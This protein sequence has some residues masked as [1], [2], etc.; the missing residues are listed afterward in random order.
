MKRTRKMYWYE[1]FAY[2][3]TGY[4]AMWMI[5]GLTHYIYYIR[6]SVVERRL[7]RFAGVVID[8]HLRMGVV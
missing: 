5:G 1:I 7:G 8:V 4:A 3:A 2:I 6:G